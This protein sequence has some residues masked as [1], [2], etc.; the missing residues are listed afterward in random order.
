MYYTYV[1]LSEKDRNFYVGYTNDL[2]ERFSKH[3]QGLV[4][5][6]AHRRPLNLIYYEACLDEEDAI[7]REKYLKSGYGRRFLKNR[8]ATYLKEVI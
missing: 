1:L 6:T 3:Q 7:K 8:L 2:K 4:T 5:S